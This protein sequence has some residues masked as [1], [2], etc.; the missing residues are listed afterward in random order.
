MQR[1]LITQDD[2]I[3]AVKS[4]CGKVKIYIKTNFTSFRSILVKCADKSPKTMSISLLYPL[5]A[6]IKTKHT[7]ILM[8]I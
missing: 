8:D 5:I 3:L 2:T 6:I 4:V 7:W 1:N